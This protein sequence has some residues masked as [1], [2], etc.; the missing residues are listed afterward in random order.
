MDR[1]S[2]VAIIGAGLGGLTAAG[3]LQR[4]GF[5]VQVY[6]QAPAFSR[7]GAGIILSANVTKVLRRLGIEAALVEAGIKPHSYVSRA[8]DTGETMYEIVF[9]G[10]SEQR[11]GGPYLNIHRGDLHAVLESVVTPGTIAF[12]H[13]LVDLEETSD[14]IRLVFGNGTTAEADI[15]IGADG[16]RS[17]VREFVLDDAPPDFV[18]AAAY[19]AIFPA[20]RLR[21]F[22][23]PDCT[24][25]WGRDRHC[26]PYYL[27][28]RRDEV[29]AIGVVPVSRWDGDESP[30]P[31]TRQQYLE[32]FS[33]F[34]ADLQHVLEAVDSV[35]LWPI[36]DRERN[37]RWSAGPLVLLGD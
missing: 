6:E 29:Y 3:S 35:S 34:H 14:A 26:L 25:W 31:A 17:K 18:G 2:R 33:G 12:D 1:Q 10:Q 11:F 21:G 32:A 15:V 30:L 5:A 7:I 8:W 4:A 37:D 23:I 27:T 13:S 28:G 19:R 36:Y 24:K 16:I 22:K 9:D 20:Q